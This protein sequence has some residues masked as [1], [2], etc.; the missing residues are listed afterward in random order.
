M[1]QKAMVE[2]ERDRR[3]LELEHGE[4]LSRVNYLADE[5]RS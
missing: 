1:Y 2:W 3:M 4:L 5:V